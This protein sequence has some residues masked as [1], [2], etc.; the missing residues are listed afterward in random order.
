L[1]EELERMRDEA[2]IVSRHRKEVPI[3]S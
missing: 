2:Y 1:A 3:D